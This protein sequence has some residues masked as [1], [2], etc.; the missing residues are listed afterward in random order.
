[1]TENWTILKRTT[2]ICLFFFFFN[3]KFPKLLT[4]LLSKFNQSPI[5]SD[6]VSGL[7]SGLKAELKTDSGLLKSL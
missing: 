2:F 5:G 3:F 4:K 6:G 1:M 7:K